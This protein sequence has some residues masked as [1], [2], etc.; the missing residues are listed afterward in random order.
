MGDGNGFKAGGWGAT[1][2]SKIPASI[3]GHIV[4]FCLA[5]RNK[6]NGFYSNHQLAGSYW[7]NN[8]ACQNAVNFNM[9]NRLS[10]SR[11]D[12]PGYHHVMKNNLSVYPVKKDTSNIN[13]RTCD[14]SFN[15]FTLNLS[16]SDSD[17]KSTDQS[18]L[19]TPRNGDGSLPDT[20]FLKIKAGSILIDKGV[21]TGFP[22]AGLAPD[23]GAFEYQ[24]KAKNK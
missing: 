5:V 12:V 10:D 20:D 2:V 11:T 21:N 14:I 1:P 19:T 13:N 23:L 7:F 24:E 4:Q 9:L 17:F 8:T 16:V 6:A 15:S 18:L 22:F 3:P